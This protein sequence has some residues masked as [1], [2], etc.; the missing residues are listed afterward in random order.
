MTV[1]PVALS[2]GVGEALTDRAGGVEADEVA[3]GGWGVAGRP[4]WFLLIAVA[5][6]FTAAE[7]FLYQRRWIS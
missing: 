6:C 4:I 2:Q 3:P 7:W 1:E 5:I